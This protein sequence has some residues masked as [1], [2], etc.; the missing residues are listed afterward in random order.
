[1]ISKFIPKGDF[2]RNIM[3]LM[4][5]T[6]LAQA[7]PVLF[8]PLLTRIFSPA[9]FGKLAFFM[10]LC[11][12]LSIISTGRYELSVMLPKKDVEA[13][14]IMVLIVIAS[15]AISLAILSIIVLFSPY[16]L[17]ILNSPVSFQYLL[18]LPA[19]IFLTGT[20]QGLNYWLNRK[21]KYKVI[22][23]VRIL[24]SLATALISIFLGYIGFNSNGLIIGFLIGC[25]IPVVP[26]IYVLITRRSL[27]SKYQIKAIGKTYI[28]YPR[29]MMPTALM[30][31]TAMQAPVFFI[32]K[33]FSS[34]IVGSYSLASRVVT[35]PIGVISGAIGQVYFQK[36][37]TIVSHHSGT[38]LPVVLKTARTLVLISIILFTPF[39]FWGEDLFRVIFGA[40]WGEAGKYVEIISVAMFIRFIVSPLSTIFISTNRIRVG[41]AWQTFYFCTTLT[42]FFVGRNLHFQD[43][44]WLY[45]IHEIVL[46]T[47]YFIL[48]LLVSRDFDKNLICAE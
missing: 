40:Q 25:I 11:A 36:V 23:T 30:D 33:F 43:L 27:I 18:L 20:F 26:L 3:T 22:S 39:F 32:N 47:I 44:L 34:V 9:E 12:I 10:S 1:M 5:G 35:A 38:V 8:S 16:I 17:E 46:Y 29:F 15:F 4:T 14:N 7:I 41:A 37:A 45:V 28:D 6:G 21:K 13:F 42:I 2:S 48:M 24:Q 31:T 19:G